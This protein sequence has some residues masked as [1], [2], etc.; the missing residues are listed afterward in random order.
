MQYYSQLNLGVEY[1]LSSEAT[2]KNG[3]AMFPGHCQYCHMLILT[4]ML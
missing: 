1:F 3:W 4:Y 2:G